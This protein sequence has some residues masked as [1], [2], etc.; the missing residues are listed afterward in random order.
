[1]V[2]N[3][4]MA[5]EVGQEVEKLLRKAGLT[6]VD[7]TEATATIR[8]LQ[9]VRPIANGAQYRAYEERY[10]Q[11]MQDA[12]FVSGQKRSWEQYMDY[13]RTPAGK[14]ALVLFNRMAEWK[15]EKSVP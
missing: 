5:R 14:L 7:A 8:S 6:E 11:M 13:V 9:E 15:K 4:N 10:H 3:D 2:D 1:M 12:G